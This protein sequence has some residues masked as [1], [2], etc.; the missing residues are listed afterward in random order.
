MS[1]DF[2]ENIIDS[3]CIRKL[4]LPVDS[5]RHDPVLVVVDLDL[6]GQGGVGVGGQRVGLRGPGVGR[7]VVSGMNNV[8]SVMSIVQTEIPCFIMRSELTIRQRRAFSELL[9]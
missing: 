5:P 9:V 3:L 7:D 1:Y 6:G 2:S 4:V 8:R